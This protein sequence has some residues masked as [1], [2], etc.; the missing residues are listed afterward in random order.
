MAQSSIL[1]I[2]ENQNLVM[3]LDPTK[4]DGFL[5]P[6]VECLHYSPLVVA[7]MKLEILPLVHLSKPYSIAIYQKGEEMIIFK[8]FNKKTNNIKSRLCCLLGLPQGRELV[9]PEIVS[10]SAILETF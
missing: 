4:Y 5:Q 8:I 9:D 10:N 6:L 1:N 2:K 3:D 7:L